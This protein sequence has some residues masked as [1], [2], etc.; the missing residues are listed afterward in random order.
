MR[1]GVVG[2][3]TVGTMKD[4]VFGLLAHVPETLDEFAQTQTQLHQMLDSIC[5]F[6]RAQSSAIVLL[7]EACVAASTE[8]AS[9]QGAIISLESDVKEMRAQL[10]NPPWLSQLQVEQTARAVCT[11]E[12]TA[13]LQ[14]GIATEI[15][16]EI[17]SHQRA[18]KDALEK[19]RCAVES[20]AELHAVQALSA[21]SVERDSAWQTAVSTITAEMDQLRDQLGQAVEHRELAEQLR[22]LTLEAAEVHAEFER[23]LDEKVS[24]AQLDYA[25]EDKLDCADGEAILAEGVDTRRIAELAGQT[26]ARAEQHVGGMRTEAMAA[27]EESF[28]M[29]S[30]IRAEVSA[31]PPEPQPAVSKDSRL[32][33]VLSTALATISPSFLCVPGVRSLV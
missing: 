25:L 10:Q 1:E 5:D 7:E 24:S 21:A 26:A 6:V 28:H 32:V 12:V 16:Q 17:T 4:G 29:V 30:S 27:L 14:G 3:E 33:R 11:Q 31:V 19:L 22:S 2:P 23:K 15:R 20:K 8:R 18:E 13:T 9:M